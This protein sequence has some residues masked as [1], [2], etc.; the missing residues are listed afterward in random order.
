MGKPV[1]R[2]YYRQRQSMKPLSRAQAVEIVTAKKRPIAT[3]MNTPNE[4]LWFDGFPEEVD[5]R[6]IHKDDWEHVGKQE[7]GTVFALQ[8]AWY[9]VGREIDG[10]ASERKE[11]PSEESRTQQIRQR[12]G[13][14]AVVALHGGIS[15]VPYPYY[16]DYSEGLLFVVGTPESW[17]VERVREHGKGVYGRTMAENAE[18]VAFLGAKFLFLPTGVEDEDEE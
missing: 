15:P 2:T 13:L 16:H 5:R 6:S 14:A 18:E 10:R 3:L 11:Q 1:E 4:A 17:T 12:L 8:S 9:Q 7:S